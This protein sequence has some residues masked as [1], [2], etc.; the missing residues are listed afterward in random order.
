M[1]GYLL[2]RETL[3]K[4]MILAIIVLLTGIT[5]L[6]LNKSPSPASLTGIHESQI[7]DHMFVILGGI[8]LSVLVALLNTFRAIIGKYLFFKTSY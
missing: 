2:F 7:P 5:I 3:S 8:S 1:M 4:W 6:A